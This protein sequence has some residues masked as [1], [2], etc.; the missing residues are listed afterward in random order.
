MD[1][2]PKVLRYREP[3]KSGLEQSKSTQNFWP[4]RKLMELLDWLTLKDYDKAQKDGTQKAI[5]MIDH[6]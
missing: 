4:W 1:T 6:G 3:E 2:E 5:R